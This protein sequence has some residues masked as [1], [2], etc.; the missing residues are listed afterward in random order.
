MMT[1]TISSTVW[2]HA[3]LVDFFSRPSHCLSIQSQSR[4]DHRQDSNRCPVDYPSTPRVGQEREANSLSTWR[5]RRDDCRGKWS[6]LLATSFNPLLVV[7]P[8]REILLKCQPTTSLPVFLQN[9]RHPAKYDAAQLIS[10]CLGL[11]LIVVCCSFRRSKSF[12]FKGPLPAVFW[13]GW[14]LHSCDC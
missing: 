11:D 1:S 14:Q 10:V 2:W 6:A 9:G 13:P 4:Q 7:S 8:R 12:L 5:T 3:Q